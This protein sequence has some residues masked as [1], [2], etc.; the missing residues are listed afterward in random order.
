MPACA[1]SYLMQDLARDTWGF[2][3]YVVSDCGAVNNIGG[4]CQASPV[5]P[6]GG[7]Y[8]GR[9][10]RVRAP[11][12]VHRARGPRLTVRQHNYTQTI[13]E[14]C[15]LAITAGCELSCILFYEFCADAVEVRPCA[16]P[17]DGPRT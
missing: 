7:V 16:L 15:A 3:G 17:W 2:N 4:R 1:N 11:T 14:T 8:A 12:A 6:P 5:A 13:D 10:C 9:S